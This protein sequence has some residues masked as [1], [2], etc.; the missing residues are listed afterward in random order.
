MD[1]DEIEL[2]ELKLKVDVWKTIVDTQKHF[3]DLEMSVRNFGILIISAFLGAIGV[4]FGSEYAFEMWG[5]SIPVASLLAFGAA[6]VWSVFYFVDAYWYHPLL[7]GAVKKGIEIENEIKPRLNNIDLAAAIGKESPQKIFGRSKWHST[8]K[9][10]F[11]YRS[12]LVVLLVL[13]VLFLFVAKP[14]GK[15]RKL[16]DASAVRL[17]CSG[18]L[19]NEL[20]CTA[21]ALGKEGNSQMPAR[22]ATVKR[23]PAATSSGRVT[24]APLPGGAHV[25]GGGLG[26]VGDKLESG[27]N[28]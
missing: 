2:E 1:R 27:K 6:I 25:S 16:Q 4:S 7:I 23:V 22:D 17:S 8:D 18:N 15:E 19:G 11:F 12:I 21:R 26:G 9:L 14:D 5:R 3:N 13:G 28:Q 24:N 10:K 20:S